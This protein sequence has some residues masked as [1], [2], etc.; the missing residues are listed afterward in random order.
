VPGP[1]PAANTAITASSVTVTGLASLSLSNA[2]FRINGQTATTTVGTNAVTFASSA[3]L[4]LG[5][6]VNEIL[7]EAELPGGE[8]VTVHHLVYGYEVVGYHEVLDDDWGHGDDNCW[9]VQNFPHSH[10]YRGPSFGQLD[11]DAPAAQLTSAGDSGIYA[12]AE[13]CLSPACGPGSHS[14]T[15]DPEYIWVDG[16]GWWHT[17]SVIDG[18]HLEPTY[19]DFSN[20]VSAATNC[21]DTVEHTFWNGRYQAKLTFIKHAPVHEEQVVLL[22]FNDVYYWKPPAPFWQGGSEPE[23]FTFWGEPGIF[24]SLTEW[25]STNIAFRVKVKTNTRYTISESDFTYPTVSGTFV[26]KWPNQQSTVTEHTTVH[27]L[28]FEGVANQQEPIEVIEGAYNGNAWAAVWNKLD[29][30]AGNVSAKNKTAFVAG[31]IQIATYVTQSVPANLSAGVAYS[32]AINGNFFAIFGDGNNCNQLYGFV[33]TGTPPW[34]CGNSIKDDITGW[35]GSRWGFGISTDGAQHV[36][37]HDVEDP[38]GT[39]GYFPADDVKQQPYGLNNVGLLIANRAPNYGYRSWPGG[40]RCRSLLVWSQ[41]K[42]HLFE[43]VIGYAGNDPGLT[44]DQTI[45]FV[46]TNLRDTVK[47]KLGDFEVGDAVML[48]GG[49][50]AQ[51]SFRRVIAGQPPSQTDW[52][53]ANEW[54]EWTGGIRMVPTLVNTYAIIPQN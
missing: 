45:D 25:L 47:K 38:N 27:M 50:S 34:S 49:S 14:S 24:H 29:L 9:Y 8:T 33:G 22:H 41:D 37:R 2:T 35:P 16:M 21:I 19:K 4:S 54:V 28:Q 13:D 12:Y 26:S 7:V 31:R 30:G 18:K 39:I 1:S 10:P 42:K 3:P 51:I 23:Q 5:A 15:W 11:W 20:C 40:S 32:S 46:R 17:T 44:W 53:N 36:I 43:I 48:D 52:V 6:E